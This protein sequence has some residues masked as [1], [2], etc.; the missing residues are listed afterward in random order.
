MSNKSMQEHAYNAL[1]KKRKPVEFKALWQ[2]VAS[3][4]G[5][6]SATAQSRMVKFYNSLS[7]DAR[8]YQLSGN[9]WDLASRHSVETIRNYKKKFDDIEDDEEIDEYEEEIDDS[10]DITMDDDE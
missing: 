6:E 3:E 2:E 9:M 1:K 5:L 10:L 4:M 8:F 7:L